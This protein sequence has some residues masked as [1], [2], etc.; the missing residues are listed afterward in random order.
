MS[1]LRKIWDLLWS[2]LGWIVS[3]W[4]LLVKAIGWALGQLTT[5]LFGWMS[6]RVY[7]GE[8]PAVDSLVAFV[9]DH[10]ALD[11]LAEVLATIIA[12]RIATRIA[13][14]SLIPI[15]ALLDLF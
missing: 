10:L 14:A 1:W 9:L 7:S 4:A 3:L 5:T 8:S 11:T 12:V 2:P 13:H 15:R 6:E